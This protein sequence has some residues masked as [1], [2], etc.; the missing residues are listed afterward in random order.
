[1]KQESTPR[2]T[3]TWTPA[4]R[5]QFAVRFAQMDLERLRPGDRLNV[6]DDFL[7]FVNL[8]PGHGH[9]NGGDVALRLEGKARELYQPMFNLG[10]IGSVDEAQGPEGLREEVV[11]AH[12]PV[13]EQDAR[14]IL[15]AFTRPN[16]PGESWTPPFVARCPRGII[17]SHG[18]R[19][20]GNLR[21]Y[22]NEHLL[23]L[24]GNE[25][26]DRILRCPECGTIFYR[27]QKQAYCSRKCGNRV[28]QRRWRARH[29]VATPTTE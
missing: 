16:Q 21:Q 11:D 12:L 15:E 18:L 4:D 1:M 6:R 25:P 8:L 3:Q 28:T 5:L 14:T 17:T 26:P 27:V 9:S 24:L 19:V 13:A 7:W 10:L 2:E 29:D 20:Q 22:F 23:H